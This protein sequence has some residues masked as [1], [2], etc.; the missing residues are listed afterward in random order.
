MNGHGIDACACG[1]VVAQCRCPGPHTPRVVRK[2]CPQCVRGGGLERELEK[3][4]ASDPKVAAAAA[5]LERVKHEIIAR[6]GDWFV[7]Y[8][9][10]QFWPFD[11]RPADFDHADIAHALAHVCRYA[12]HCRRFYSVAQHSVHV[13]QIVDRQRPDLAFAALM[14]DAAEAY[15]GD[16]IRPIKRSHPVFE[17]IERLVWV[18]MGVRFGLPEKLDPLIKY[19]DN[20]A[21][22]TER[23]D[24]VN[25]G[26]SPK[27]REDELGILPDPEPIVPL[28]PDDAEQLWLDAFVRL[29]ADAGRLTDA[30]YP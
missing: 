16:V 10:R 11:P 22:V 13:M 9:G 21:L 7:T 2:T 12:G 8:T 27:W 14:H 23:R 3:L 28:A 18:A 19:A 1:A 6:K 25:M 24:L 20:V 30:D 15:V 17:Q 4:E 5:A 29:S 26:G